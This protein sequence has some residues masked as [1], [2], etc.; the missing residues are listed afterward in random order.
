VLTIDRKLEPLNDEPSSVAQASYNLV[1]PATDSPS[2]SV[3]PGTYTSTQ[4]VIISDATPGAIIYYTTDGT[5]PTSSSPQYS[6]PIT[7]S[8][9]D[10]I[11]AIA[12]ASGYS[13]S[14]VASTSYTINLTPPTIS[15]T[16]TA[17]TL[18]PGASTGNT[19]TI[20]LTPGSGF[21][22][23]VALT[24]VLASS[25]NG[26]QNLP[27]FSFGSTTPVSITSGDAATATLT[28]STTAATSAAV[29]HS[30]R[31]GVPW[32]VSG[33]ATL[34][35]I[36]LFGT[37]TRRRRWQSMFGMLMLLA[38]LTSGVF[39]CGGGGNTGGGGTSN[40]GTTPGTYTV[41]VTGT[42]GATTGSGTVTLTV[43]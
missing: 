37:P 23:S 5:T 15:I 40:P 18:S 20:T 25:P 38:L 21:I 6:A 17:V 22:G 9:T 26:A 27:T 24:A 10:T 14:N 28:I 30:K 42:S 29:V 3:A 34:G 36:L 43:Q 4:T 32:Y 41:T 1:L 31:P 33:S 13:A 12:I 11:N 8:K 2:F 35:C 19:S 7:V 39:A 16:G